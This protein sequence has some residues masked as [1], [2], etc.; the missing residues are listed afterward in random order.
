MKNTLVTYL[1]DHVAGS[2]L[3]IDLLKSLAKQYEGAPLGHFA[4]SIQAEVQEDRELLEDLLQRLGGARTNFLKEAAAW[5]VEKLS[6][7][8]LNRRT[9]GALGT[10]EALETLA[11]VMMCNR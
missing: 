3:A 11:L 1:H 6:R 7:L 5:L 4:R 9:G 2:R 8:K 10:F